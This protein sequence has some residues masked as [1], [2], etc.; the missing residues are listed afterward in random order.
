MQYPN[1][2]LHIDT[3]GIGSGV[4]DRLKEQDEISDRVCGVNSAVSATDTEAYKNL[5]A[6]GW[7]DARQW[8][9]DA[10][11]DDDIEHKEKWYQLA[12]PKYKILSSG[13]IQLESKE[14]M[15][16]RGIPSPGVGDALVLTLQ[17][18][19]EGAKF[20]MLVAD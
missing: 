18:P 7:D 10:V 4:Y 5:R 2:K 6:E 13:Q 9:R 1:A 17:R 15:K 12:K 3:I 8:L 11:L 14:D 20:M 19:T 16:K